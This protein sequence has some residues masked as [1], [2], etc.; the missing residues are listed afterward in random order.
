M[1]MKTL[2]SLNGIFAVHK[3][4]G[5]TSAQL[6]E[7]IKD[8]VQKELSISRKY[9]KFGHGGTLDSTATGVLV[10]GSGSATPQLK[11]LIGG[12]KEYFVKGC[13]GKSTDTLN[14]AGKVT[15][16]LPFDHVTESQLAFKL[17]NFQGRIKQVPPLYSALKLK[18]QRYSDI[19]REGN[20]ITPT[21]RF[22]HC[23]EAQLEGF[24]PPFFTLKLL[25]GRGFYVRSL[26]NDLGKEVGSCAHVCELVRTRQGPFTLKNSLQ[27]DQ[28]SVKNITKAIRY[29]T[30]KKNKYVQDCI[31]NKW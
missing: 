12:E 18:G 10:I 31:D 11:Y 3:P 2:K 25:T 30:K 13:L 6:L 15:E 29:S 17:L 16:E 14:E 1:C 8:I 24:S 27:E 22:V 23:Y 9:I 5:I 28:W 4:Y 20:S 19:A 21:A 26:V 7:K